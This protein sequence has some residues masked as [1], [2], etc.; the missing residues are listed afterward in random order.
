MKHGLVTLVIMMILQDTAT[1]QVLPVF[2]VS[3]F[4][5]WNVTTVEMFIYLKITSAT[6]LCLLPAVLFL[7]LWSCYFGL[8]LVSSGLGLGL[9]NLVLFTSLIGI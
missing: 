5:D 3:L 9:K 2:I 4:C 1:F 6:C 7:V 8:G